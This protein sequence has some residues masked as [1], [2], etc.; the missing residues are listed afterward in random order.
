MSARRHL[1]SIPVEIRRAACAFHEAGHIL[2]GWRYQRSISHAWLRPPHG[3][4]GETCF[5]PYQ[6]EFR[7]ERQAD[8]A[9]AEAEISILYGGYCGEMI[10]WNQ[11]EAL[12]WYPGE[13]ES[14]EDDLQQMLPYLRFIAPPDEAVFRARCVR[15]ATA[16]LHAPAMQS[17][18]RR[19]A[20]AL[21]ADRRI[22]QDAVSALI[23]DGSVSP[24]S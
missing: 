8:I 7:R 10:Y 19:I 3:V 13:L 1:N 11:P 5:E 2:V 15:A 4:S 21:I 23:Q 6:R 14:H 12:R 24:N 18:L 20:A 17:A 22:G 16:I 9:R